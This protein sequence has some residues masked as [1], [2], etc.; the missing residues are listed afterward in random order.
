MA[1]T[2]DSKSCAERL[3]GSSPP[4]PTKPHFSPMETP[5]QSLHSRFLSFNTREQYISSRTD[6]RQ[7]YA[8]ISSVIRSNKNRAKSYTRW[9]AKIRYRMA[10][11]DPNFNP[12]EFQSRLSMAVRNTPPERVQEFGATELLSIRAEMKVLAGK[13]MFANLAVRNA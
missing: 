12:K 7:L 2:L 11:K 9:N 10:K 3:G 8:H 4:A 13:Q 5:A 1:N 6:W